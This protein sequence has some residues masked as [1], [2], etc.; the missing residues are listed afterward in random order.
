M[1][2]KSAGEIF[3]RRDSSVYPITDLQ[4][5]GPLGWRGDLVTPF[6]QISLGFEPA[7]LRI[8]GL[9]GWSRDDAFYSD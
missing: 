8:A 9:A 6:I 7:T 1:N 5:D 2:L 4:K 3:P